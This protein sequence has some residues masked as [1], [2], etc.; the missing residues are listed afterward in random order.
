MKY[1]VHMKCDY[2][3]PIG[4]KD[5]YDTHYI[6]ISPDGATGTD[7]RSSFSEEKSMECENDANRFIMTRDERK[8]VHHKSEILV[9]KMCNTHF[10]HQEVPVEEISRDEYVSYKLLRS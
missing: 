9:F 8:A 6:R 7:A 5:D 4:D 10:G 2:L 3:I 1:R